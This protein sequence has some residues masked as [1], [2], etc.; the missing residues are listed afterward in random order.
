MGKE[1]VPYDLGRRCVGGSEEGFEVLCSEGFE[2]D[3]LED[4]EC[5][6]GVTGC[7]EGVEDSVDESGA[8]GEDGEGGESD[9][10][11]E[12]GGGDD[13]FHWDVDGESFDEGP[14]GTLHQLDVVRRHPF[15]RYLLERV[16]EGDSDGSDGLAFAMPEELSL[17]EVEALD[18]QQQPLPR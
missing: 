15:F 8:S 16:E 13:V 14:H 12:D 6:G 3:R 10:G 2:G 4:L 7:D 5:A 9:E 1:L 18:A 17:S 11:G